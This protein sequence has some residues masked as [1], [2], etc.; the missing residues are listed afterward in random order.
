MPSPKQMNVQMKYRLARSRSY[1]EH[2]AVALFN[3][4]LARNF[5]CGQ[6]AAPDDFGIACL[7][8]L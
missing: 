2:G 6:M 4:S 1:V 7:G 3:L 8:F 5:C